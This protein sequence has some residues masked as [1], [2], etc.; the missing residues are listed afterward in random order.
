MRRRE[1][2]RPVAKEETAMLRHLAS[3]RCLVDGLRPLGGRL[4]LFAVGAGLTL[5]VLVAC[6]IRPAWLE[7]QDLKLYDTMLTRQRRL[8]RSGL[9]VIVDI[10]E[11]S[12]A[13]Y[14]QWPW[15][16]YRVAL[17]LGLL[18]NAGVRAAGLDILFA[19]PDR[20]SPNVLIGQM[21]R[22]LKIE[23]AVSG[24]PEA[25]RDYDQVLANTLG[26]GPFVLGYYFDFTETRR[27]IA[28]SD[29]LPVLPLSV[30]R[31]PGAMELEACLPRP[32]HPVRPLP[33]LLATGGAAGFFNTLSDRDNILRRTPLF[34]AY[35]GKVY[36]SLALATVM[37]AYGLKSATVR[38]TP[39]GVES[40]VLSGGELGRRVIPLD[41][42]G[43]VLLNYRGPG[44]AFPHVSAGDVLA[45]RI[46]PGELAGKI[47][48][49]GT[50]AAALRD[51][52]ASPL[53]R[54]MPGVEA[55]ATIADMIVSDDFL[56]RP[57]WATGAEVV[58]ILIVG[59]GVSGLLTLAGALALIGP[60]VALAAGVWYGAAWLLAQKGLYVSPLGPLLALAANFVVLTFLKF[61]R[62]ERQKRFLHGAFSHYLAPAVVARIAANPDAL[63]LTG[64]ERQVTMLFSDVRGFT[65]ISE[66]LS[67]TQVVE[68]L[69]QY[70]TPMTRIITGNLG[71]LDKFIGD[72]I[73]AFWNAPVDVPEH[74]D[75]A[76]RSALA[77][78]EELGRLNEGFRATYGFAVKAGIGLHCGMVRVG[79]FGSSE[80]FNYT[81]MGDAVNLCSRLEGLTK[82]YGT[83]LLVTDAVRDAARDDL[84]FQEIDLVRVKGKKE[85]FV[86][87][88]VLTAA[89]R[90]EREQEL[91]LAEEARALYK[92]RRFVEAARLYEALAKRYPRRLHEVFFRRAAALALAAPPEN[93]DGVFD[94][95]TK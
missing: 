25:L 11:K 70:F 23:V 6:L 19:E 63:T 41:A 92:A 73:M 39:A 33:A 59:I 14:G 27:R 32:D 57:D 28:A 90:A 82:Y 48:F 83:P 65:S 74:Q 77:M 60:F 36:P 13:E 93:W 52:R 84:Y 79:N 8:M 53:D 29:G 24:L 72:A 58:G 37:R 3:I 15:P 47:V 56:S 64:E 31:A 51:L 81:V 67:P 2:G 26:Q 44:G 91:A 76:V 22:D 30:L 88:T 9:P 42:S 49:V 7:F 12:L 46:Q 38:L 43:R 5:I 40:L 95:T 62:E 54:A 68:L 20:T 10:D 34:L 89:Q 17:L 80:L 21:L 45:G 85:P 71:T 4:G 86:I 78:R 75:L 94:H 61:W 16:R 18:R 69:H 35:K 50:S 55:H 87:H 66:S 1:G